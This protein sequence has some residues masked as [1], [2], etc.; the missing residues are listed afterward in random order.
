MLHRTHV[1]PFL[2]E[3]DGE[4]HVD[5]LGTR[6]DRVGLLNRLCRLVRRLE[7]HPRAA[8]A[9]ALRRQERRVRDTR[10]LSGVAKALLDACEFRAAAGA[11]RAAEVRDALFRARAERW[12][13]VPGDR[14]LIYQTA[15]TA[16]GVAAAEIE[17]LLYADRPDQRLLVQAPSFDGGALLDRY[18]LELARA[19]LL[20]AV[21]LTLTARGGWRAIFRAVK[22]A[23]LM[24]RIEPAGRRYRVELTGPAAPF[25]TRPQRYGARLARIVPSLVRAPGWH[26]DAEIRHGDRTLRFQLDSRAPVRGRARRAVYDSA[27]ERALA[28]EFRHR[29]ESA[30]RAG[31]SLHREHTPVAA[32]GELFLPDFT[33]RH[34]DGREA[35]VEVVGFWTPDYLESKLAKVEAA[36]LRHLVLVVYDGL[37]AGPLEAAAAGPVIR[38]KATPSMAAVLAAAEGVATKPRRTTPFSN[39]E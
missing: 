1:A 7:G 38:F 22:L 20:D 33:L 36:G 17:R 15:G 29:L 21:R 28:H 3:R 5:F 10:R 11:E 37:A 14:S 8:V 2:Q 4:L 35:L 23:R 18:N 13:P 32:A 19:V 24:Y 39:S 34:R 9:E 12:P 31:W 26:L 25:V 16:L 27:W 30:E 6:P